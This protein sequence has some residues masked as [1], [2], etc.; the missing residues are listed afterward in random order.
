MKLLQRNEIHM[1]VMILL[2]CGDKTDAVEVYVS[3][4]MYM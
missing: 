2:A 1:A 4:S 3:H